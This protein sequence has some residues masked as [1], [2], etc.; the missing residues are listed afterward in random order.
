MAARI[1]GHDWAATPLG[2]ARRLAAEPAHRRADRAQ[3]ALRHVDGVGPRADVLLQR[4]LR[5]RTRSPPSTRGRSGSARD[6]VWAEIWEDIGPRIEQ[7][8]A[9]GTATWDEGLRLFLERSGYREETYHTFSYSPLSDDDGPH[10]R[11]AV[12]RRR[13]DRARDRRAA[14]ARRCATS[15]RRRPPPR[16]SAS[17][18]RAVDRSLAAQPRGPAVRVRLHH[19]RRRRGSLTPVT[20]GR[21][22]LAGGRAARRRGS[23]TCADRPGPAVGRLAGAAA[24]GA[25]D[26]A[27]RPEPAGAGGRAASPASTRTGRSTRPTAASS[28]CV[29]GQIAASLASVRAREAERRRAEALA[30]L[31]RAKTDFFSNVSHEFRTPLS[32]ILGPA[33]DALRGRRRRRAGGAPH[34]RLPQR[35]APAE[36]RQ[37]PAR[38]LAHRGRARRARARADRPRRVHRRPREH[39]PRG[40]RPRRDRARRRAPGRRR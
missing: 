32:L 5:A 27:R 36:A 1:A 7:V 4:R 23:S 33:E 8:L 26:R 6:A 19:R 29:G 17:C 35:A 39:V 14:P 13:G 15:R 22:R 18:S 2:P 3:L 38:V 28:S 37:Q 34:R 20:A 25:G 12:R 40:H 9:T 10:R 31:D 21:A 24:R 16:P 11:D 30:E